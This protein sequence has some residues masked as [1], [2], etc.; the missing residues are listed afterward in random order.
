MKENENNNIINTSGL[1]LWFAD[2]YSLSIPSMMAYR[3]TLIT[4]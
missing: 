2:M 1:P 4:R 3:Y